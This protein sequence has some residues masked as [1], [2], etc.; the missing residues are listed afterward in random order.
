MLIGSKLAEEP[1]TVVRS[2]GSSIRGLQAE[3]LSGFETYVPMQGE[4]LCS[5][6]PNAGMVSMGRC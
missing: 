2:F 5:L 4:R 3:L 6:R 1:L